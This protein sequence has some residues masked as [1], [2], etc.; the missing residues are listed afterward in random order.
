MGLFR[1]LRALRKQSKALAKESGVDTS[2]RGLMRQTPRLIAQATETLGQVENGKAEGDRLRAGGVPATGRLIAVR[3]TGVT[4]GGGTLGAA[5][6][7]S[8]VAE[9]DFEV[10][11]EGHDPYRASATQLVPRLAVGR[12][13]PGS[14]LPLKVDPEDP[15]NVL[16]DWEAPV[17]P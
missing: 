13:V 14:D 10:R 1:E 11:R 5:N 12:L 3:D 7:N 6:Q 16:V 9:L 15:T 17:E 4:L 2:L 8:A